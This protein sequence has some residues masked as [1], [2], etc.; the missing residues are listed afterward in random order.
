MIRY[1]ISV[2]SFYF[3]QSLFVIH[4]L[5]FSDGLSFTIV[6]IRRSLN[7]KEERFFFFCFIVVFHILK[8]V[9]TNINY[10]VLGTSTVIFLSMHLLLRMN[11]ILDFI[12]LASVDLRGARGKK[13][14]MK[15]ICSWWDSELTTLRFVVRASTCWT[16]LAWWKLSF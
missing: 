3:F 13:Y 6:C 4:R 11:V 5:Q 14:K 8:L 16:S 1:F 7:V 15:N 9:R 10:I 12:C 2:F